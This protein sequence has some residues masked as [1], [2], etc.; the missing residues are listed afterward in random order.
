M[1]TLLFLPTMQRGYRWIDLTEGAMP[2]EGD[3]IPATAEDIVA[4]A[5][6]EAV[7]LHWAALPDRSIAQAT[8]A[9]R[10]LAAEA[11]AAP[12]A[13]LHIAVGDEGTPERPIGVVGVE[14]M[15]AWL[16]AL[17]AEGIDPVAM[18]PA[19]MLLP[20]PD[21][22]YVRA[23]M[24]GEGVVRGPTSGFADEARLT[25]LVTG[26]KAPTTL[27]RATMTVALVDG[28]E[29]PPLDLRQGIFARRT[30]R[31]IDWALIRRLAMLGAGILLLTL[32]IDLVRIV[33]YSLDAEAMEAR[34]DALGRTGLAR[35][36][37][38]TDVDRQL[39]ERLSA[40]RGPGLGFT[41][42][43]AAVYSAVRAVPGVEIT[44]LDFQA[45]GELRLTLATA[46][47]ALVTDVKTALEA[48]GFD[49]RAGVF[50]SGSGRVTGEMTVTWR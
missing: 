18:V 12:L 20:R 48:A 46:R 11:S 37:T 13:E 10:I 28:A 15:R 9:A 22:G 31:A 3:G 2:R 45:N 27:D 35:G 30:R 39:E 41:T 40:V 19:P 34:A 29:A 5:P 17:A 36:E 50:Q 24:A 26:G 7:T 33:R 44:A 14:Q 1:T 49:V 43:T 32:A 25:E 16:G 23:Q 8:A 47:E 38:V 6:A 21:E 42:T 4:I